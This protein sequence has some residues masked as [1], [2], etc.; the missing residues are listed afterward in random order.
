MRAA[1]SAD[2]RSRARERRERERCRCRPSLER[3]RAEGDA[4]SERRP[5]E[6]ELM[7]FIAGNAES[8]WLCAA[9]GAGALR[10]TPTVGIAVVRAD[11]QN[12]ASN[13]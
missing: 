6:A 5:S 12:I 8:A 7:P 9:R 2:A 10:R 4:P 1:R 11:M 3:R 13:Y